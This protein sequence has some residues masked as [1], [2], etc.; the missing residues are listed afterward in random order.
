AMK[1]LALAGPGSMRFELAGHVRLARQ[2]ASESASGL[3]RTVGPELGR[4]ADALDACL[5]SRL[6][7]GADALLAALD[8]EPIAAEIDG[9]I[10][11]LLT[12]APELL[13]QVG[14]ALSAAGARIRELLEVF[15]P[16]A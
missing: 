2:A 14:A 12:K 16:G 11:A 6:A 3:V 10:G 1:A 5:L 15:N 8:P 4:I 7:G 13:N 9:L